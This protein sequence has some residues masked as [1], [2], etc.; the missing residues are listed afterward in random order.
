MDPPSKKTSCTG[1]RNSSNYTSLWPSLKAIDS[2]FAVSYAF[3][4]EEEGTVQG[5][6]EVVLSECICLVREEGT[7]AQYAVSL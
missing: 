3:G 2:T 4:R 5:D 1:C 7:V 6:I